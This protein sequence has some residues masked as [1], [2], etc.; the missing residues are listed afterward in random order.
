MPAQA[1]LTPVVEPLQLLAGT[2]KELHLHLLKLAHAEDELTGHNL[3]AEGLADLCD[4]KGDAHAAGLLHIQE[5]HENALCGL[6]TQIHVHRRVGAAAHLRL[7]HEVELTHVGPVLGTA[8]GVHDLVIDDN[9]L[10][11]GQV[12]VVHGLLV[13][14]MQFV[15]LLLVLEHAG[16]G[17]AEHRLV[18]LV[19]EAL[20]GLLAFLVHLLL[21]LGNLVLDEH[22]GAVALL[23]VAVVNQGIVECVHVARSLPDGRVHEDGAVDAHDVLVQQRH[24]L[25]P[26]ALDIVFQLYAV[27][28]I[29]IHSA[30]AVIDFTRREHKAIFLGVRHDF[31]ENV[32]LF[33][34][35]SVCIVVFDNILVTKPQRYKISING[36]TP[37][38]ILGLFNGHC[39]LTTACRPNR[40]CVQSLSI[41]HGHAPGWLP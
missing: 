3:V 28:C 17:L 39:S 34:H 29:V 18:K 22:V 12:V 15:T 10:Q 11:L 41:V 27:L 37:C 21:D 16:I 30:Q 25:P 24:G 2:Y 38:W 1:L 9:L 32:F 31:L 13:A 20:G 14:G 26:V 23:A 19:A 35:C 6:G 36:T 7:E 4:A 8:H 5:V 33:C 40:I